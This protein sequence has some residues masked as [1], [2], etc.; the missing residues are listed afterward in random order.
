[1]LKNRLV[2]FSSM[3]VEAYDV[4][5]TWMRGALVSPEGIFAREKES[6]QRDFLGQI[7][8][9]SRK[10]RMH[11]T[12]DCVSVAVP[13]PV[14][15]DVLYGA[16]PLNRERSI[17][18]AKGLSGLEKKVFVEN[19]LN[20]A[21]LTEMHEGYGRE[22]QSFYLLTISTGIGVGIVLKGR[23]VGGASGEFGHCNVNLRQFPLQCACGRIGCWAAYASGPG[24]DNFAQKF[25]S[26]TK[27]EV[28]E[29]KSLYARAVLRFL[30]NV[31]ARGLGIMVN[32]LDVQGIVVMG[33]LGLG[34][35]EKIIPSK[36]NIRKYAFNSVPPIV[37][38]ELGDD[39]G[40][41]GA[42]YVAQKPCE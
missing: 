1:M 24:I 19:D 7:R 6:T 26:I 4:G 41:L 15:G 42:Y 31:N 12:P 35:F 38:T 5:G 9:L 17:N 32:A 40:L 10:L 36:G 23:P 37:R 20:A 18:I 25:Y 13:G 16:P 27:E 28:F 8:S 34:Q 11:G 29:G 39:I 14:K 30:R 3:I 33:S 21:A 22:W 2:I